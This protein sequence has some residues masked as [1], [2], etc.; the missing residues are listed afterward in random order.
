VH[1]LSDLYVAV[2]AG[3]S[4]SAIGK[5]DDFVIWSDNTKEYEAN[6]PLDINKDGK[7]TKSEAA[8]MVIDRRNTYK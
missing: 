2:L 7:I 6:A 3:Q 1:S 8:Q 4:S 5:P